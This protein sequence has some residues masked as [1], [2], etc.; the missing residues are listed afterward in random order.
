MSH[1]MDAHDTNGTRYFIDHPVI[2]DPN[3]PIMLA[4]RHLLRACMSRISSKL[5][6]AIDKD[7]A[8]GSRVASHDP[9]IGLEEGMGG[10]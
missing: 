8:G 1:S 6:H 9:R 3:A 2:A 7:L 5:G 10:A 4:P